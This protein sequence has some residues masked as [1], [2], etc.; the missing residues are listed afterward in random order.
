MAAPDARG[1]DPRF[2]VGLDF[3]TTFSGYAWARKDTPDDIHVRY[4]WAGQNDLSTNVQYCKT[5]TSLLYDQTTR[6]LRSWGWEAVGQHYKQASGLFVSRFKLLLASDADVHRPDIPLADAPQGQDD[7]TAVTGGQRQLGV[8]CEG[9]PAGMRLQACIVDY[10]RALASLAMEELRTKFGAH[11]VDDDVQWC[12]TVPA[13][14]DEAAKAA[15]QRAA[16]D[17]GIVKRS[18]GRG[19]G[20]CHPLLMVLEPEAAALYAFSA[21]SQSQL[22]DSDVV[23]VVDVGGGTADVVVTQVACAVRRQLREVCRG[24]GELCGGAFVDKAFEEY[25]AA[26]VPCFER[27]KGEA[28]AEAARMLASFEPHKRAFAGQASSSWMLD[29]PA[30]LAR[31]W[32]EM[33]G[34]EDEDLMDADYDQLEVTGADMRAIFA[35]TVTRVLRLVAAMLGQAESEGCRVDALVLA[36]GFASSRYLQQLIRDRFQMQ[37]SAAEPALGAASRGA[38]AGS[39]SSHTQPV[40]AG[41]VRTVIVPQEPGAAVLVGAVLNGLTPDAYGS[42]FAR[43]TYGIKTAQRFRH[44]I[45]PPGKMFQVAPGPGQ[46]RPQRMCRDRFLCFVHNGDEVPVNQAVVHTVHPV[47]EGQ[48]RVCLRVFSTEDQYPDFVT[49]EGCVHEADVE[50]DLTEQEGGLG[51]AGP[52]SGDGVDASAVTGGLQPGAG[53]RQEIQVTFYF[54]RSQL[55]VKAASR[56]CQLQGDLET[57]LAFARQLPS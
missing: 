21:R 22:Q 40:P 44:G 24:T 52:T 51:Q 56:N 14:W 4:E 37:G 53:R 36:G 6:E 47:H 15:M 48:R 54:G 17:A 42:R 7:E 30:P 5:A 26:K 18:S 33:D 19:A 45:D 13:L 35:P 9:L 39:S 1:R 10:L 27:F 38:P 8:L 31:M 23:M 55:E 32:A 12:L 25:V 49:D 43:R 28:P 41:K 16:I 11:I 50:F 2:I 46:A 3:G 34:S 57:T 20:S 29:L